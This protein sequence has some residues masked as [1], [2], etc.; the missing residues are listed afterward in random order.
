KPLP[1]FF[2]VR[3]SRIVTSWTDTAFGGRRQ[4]FLCPSCNR[5]CAI[6]YARRASKKLC[7]RICGNGRY[8]SEL[9]SFEDR[10]LY[11]AIGI[12][13]KLGQHTGGVIVR[14]PPRPKGMHRSRYY[15]LW[16]EGMRLEA[17]VLHDVMKTLSPRQKQYL[18]E[19]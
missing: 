8:L 13:R 18:Q 4:W 17:Q 14:F 9:R 2:V 7:C 16:A 6:L 3:E 1:D 15:R 11:K 5:R 12:R 19:Y 10:R